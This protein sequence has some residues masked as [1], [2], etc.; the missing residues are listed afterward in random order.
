M[1]IEIGKLKND[2][3]RLASMLKLWFH[4]KELKE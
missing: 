2:E 1:K 4:S 3:Y